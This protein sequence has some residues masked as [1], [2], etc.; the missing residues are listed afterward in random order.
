MSANTPSAASQPVRL[1]PSERTSPG[2]NLKAPMSESRLDQTTREPKP[3]NRITVGMGRGQ[4]DAP[5]PPA[6]PGTLVIRRVHSYHPWGLTQK[7]PSPVRDSWLHRL[8]RRYPTGVRKVINYLGEEGMR[9]TLEKIRSRSTLERFS[10]AYGHFAFSGRV[11]ENLSNHPMEVDQPVVV[12]GYHGPTDADFLIARPEQVLPAPFTHPLIAVAPYLGCVIEFLEDHPEFSRVRAVGVEAAIAAIVEET[13]EPQLN[14]AGRRL[15][16]ILGESGEG[17]EGETVLRILSDR[18]GQGLLRFEQ[19]EWRV[20]FPDPSYYFID[21]YGPVALEHAPPFTSKG[22]EKA[23]SQLTPHLRP[24]EEPTPTKSLPARTLA[25]RQ[26][27]AR[28]G[29]G[30]S[31]LGAGNFSRVVLVHMLR[32]LL[33]MKIRGVMDIRPEIAAVQGRAMDATFCTTDAEAVFEDPDTDLVLIA[34]DHASH[35]DYAI[36]AIEAGKMI[37][38]EKPPSVSWE[39]FQRLLEAI[40]EHDPP[41]LNVGYNRPFAPAFRAL[42]QELQ[43]LEGPTFVSFIIKG[44]FLSR[45]HW[46]NW[47]NQGT[48]IAG[49]F[50]HWIDLGYRLTGCRL[51]EWVQVTAP[52]TSE[53]EGWDA[54]VMNI[55]FDDGSLCTLA[56]SAAGDETFGIQEYT[57]VKRQ[58]L[59]ATIENFTEMEITQEG[60]RKR[61]RFGRDK[62]HRGEMKA[63]ASY[64]TSGQGDR[65]VVCDMIVTTAIQLAGQDSLAQGGSRVEVE[66]SRVAPYLDAMGRRV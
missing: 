14:P 58:G 31:C 6:L 47:P 3:G 27:K 13:V 62:G 33:K 44:H 8:R 12:W 22:V 35:T 30:V 59:S 11:Q 24:V 50:V 54:T 23:L 55:G 38:I 64:V 46:Y 65:K 7:G 52:S 15:V 9:Q 41:M 17:V 37:H 20:S 49:N 61:R 1:G 42:D 26:G 32:D 66:M 19:D 57:D 34:S 29:L 36:R 28:P 63:L 45:A 10:T 60:R 21:P 2:D 53:S 43:S 48:R 56:F 40:R 16:V 5:A 25:L 18:R 4:I 51:P 39:Q